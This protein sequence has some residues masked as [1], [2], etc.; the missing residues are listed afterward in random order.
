VIGCYPIQDVLG[1]VALGAGSSNIWR[2]MK[3]NTAARFGRLASLVTALSGSLRPIRANRT[4]IGDCPSRET[5]Q[6]GSNV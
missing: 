1:G 3:Q 5:G 6:R 2:S 4:R